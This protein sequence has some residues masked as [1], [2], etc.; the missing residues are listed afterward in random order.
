VSGDFLNHDVVHACN[1]ATVTDRIPQE[2]TL[3]LLYS[4]RLLS[5]SVCGRADAWP[6]DQVAR[7]V[8]RV[9]RPL[10][11]TD[12]IDAQ[13]VARCNSFDEGGQQ[14]TAALSN[15]DN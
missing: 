7:R 6:K 11:E 5:F 13:S 1:Y 12:K 8:I 9:A 14:N 2:L 3:Y 10:S 4:R 15:N